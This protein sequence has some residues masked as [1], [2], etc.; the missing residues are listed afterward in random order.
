MITS[1]QTRQSKVFALLVIWTATLSGCQFSDATVVKGDGN[2]KTDS[3]L[4]E[5]FHSIDLQGAFQIHLNSGTEA[6]VRIETDENLRAFI[7]TEVQSGV[8]KI[9]A[10]RDVMLR[11]SR[12][13]IY[14]TYTTLEQ[15]SVGGA[16]RLSA[17]ETIHARELVLDTSG[18][19]DI[20]LSINA[21]SLHTRVSG[22][23]NIKLEGQTKEH[24]AELSGASNMRARELITDITK[25]SL[26]GAGS[27]QVYAGTRL[28]AK[29]S[30]IGKITYYGDPAETI[31]QKSGLGAIVNASK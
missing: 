10:E 19:V 1:F 29:I 7:N 25:I 15:V 8:L 31:I 2:I 4:T 17:A 18:A 9:Y 24:L 26:S 16:C 20:D 21:H 28:E 11:P 12:L 22:A 6:S 14:I 3:F 30:G 27:A 23:G 5:H 13:D